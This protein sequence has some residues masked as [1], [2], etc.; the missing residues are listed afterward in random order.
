MPSRLWQGLVCVSALTL[1][2]TPAN[3]TVRLVRAFMTK[4][5]P[6]SNAC[7]PTPTATSTFL[8]TDTAAYL[9]FEIENGA[10]GDIASSE[11]WTPS[12]RLLTT[13]GGAWEPLED[14]GNYCFGEKL[15]IA[16]NSQAVEGTWTVK[17]FWNGSLLAT[18]NFTIS[19]PS[20]GGGSGGG[21]GGSGGGAV[22]PAYGVNLIRNG[23]AEEGNPAGCIVQASVP[24]WTRSQGEFTTCRYG[25]PD[26]PSASSPGPPNRGNNFFWGGN[27]SKSVATQSIDVGFAAADIDRGAVSYN[28]SGYLGGYSSQDD[29]VTV[30]AIFRSSPFAIAGQVS[31]GPVLPAERQNT[32]GM[33]L[34]SATGTVPAGTRAIEIQ[35]EMNR[36]QGSANDGYA[37]NLSLVLTLGAA[38][39]GGGGGGAG[40]GGLQININQVIDTNCPNNKVIVSVTDSQGQ[41][42]S[43]L[44]SSNFTLK[45]GGQTRSITVT[46]VGAGGTSGAISLVLLIDTSS[47]LSNTDLANEKAAAKQLVSQLGASDSVAVYSF[48]S[49]VYLKQNFTTDRNAINTAIDSLSISGSTAL[50]KAV[51][52]GA[53]ALAGRTGRKA[54]VLMTDGEDTVG[55]VTIDQAIAAAKQA[56]VPVFTVGF[57][58]GIN[59]TVLQRIAQE[60]GGLFSTGASSAD[61]QRILQ[62]IGQAI[63]SQYEI[64]YTSGNPTSSNVIEITVSY[65]GQTAT[66]TRTVNAC[67]AGGGGGGGGGGGTTPGCDYFVQPL[68]QTIGGS[69]GTGLVQ[70]FTRTGCAWTAVSNTSWITIIAGASGNGQGAVSYRVDANPTASTRTGTLSIA[71]QTHTVTQQPGGAACVSQVSPAQIS[72]SGA[73]GTI[74]VMVRSSAGCTWTATSNVSWIKLASATGTASGTATFTVDPNPDTNP[75][76][77]TVTVGGQSVAVAQAAGGGADVPVIHNGGLVNAA[78][79]IGGE[80]ARGSFFTIYGA[81]LKPAPPMQTTSYPIP[82]E[83]GGVKVRIAQGSTVKWAYLH[84]VSPTQINAI[85]PSDA[86]LG[87]VEVSVITN[88][89]AGA[90]M[91]TKV[92]DVSFGIF[93]AA[94][95]LGPGIIQNWVSPSESPLNLRS[96]PASPNQIA[97]IWGTGLGP[98]PTPDNQPPAGG[99]LPTAVEVLVG[100]KSAQVLYKGR[101]PG[102]A[103]VDNIYIRVPADTPEGCSVPVQVRAAG[104]LSNTVYMAVSKSGQACQDAHNPFAS[105]AISGGKSGTIVLMRAGMSLQVEAGKPPLNLPLL[106]V[107]LAA[108]V[109]RRAGGELAYSPFANLPP[110]GSCTTQNVGL[111]L[112]SLLGAGS[113]TALDS[114]VAAELDAGAQLT[115][116]G[117]KGSGQLVRL[118]QKN[119]KGPYVG[120]LGG[121]LPSDLGFS[122]GSANMPASFLDAG[123]FTI[124]GAGGKDVGPFTANVN[125]SGGVNW[126]NRDQINDI[127]RS[128]DLTITW[129]GGSSDQVVVILGGTNDETNKRSGAFYCLATAAD[130]RFTVPASV[131]TAIPPTPAAAAGLDA[132]SSLTVGSLSLGNGPTFTAPGLNSGTILFGSLFSKSVNFR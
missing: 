121:N 4:S 115:I 23:D 108:F 67:S 59:R 12:A 116:S 81:N 62:S 102:F 69:G 5:V 3:A 42:I 45:E 122:F 110:V 80:I 123:S 71:G 63:S 92:V 88:G 36:A 70:V 28:L 128:S 65:G 66:T 35:V 126:T 113:L 119:N 39:G 41:P 78:S 112:S 89:K 94:G 55:G 47:S 106:D 10:R 51:K 83:M 95:G 90:P 96:L 18:L 129:S 82:D 50:Y 58:S 33:V 38:G 76:S 34:K 118:D 103:G 14:P 60:T 22:T 56:G 57:G 64:A 25:T 132:S 29:N 6:S 85:L 114:N 73:G 21:S 131:L 79:N 17:V 43:G 127:S 120:L 109:E 8:T 13:P 11:W 44:T 49:D 75:R 46:P 72:V 9:W 53:E 61:L 86:P 105:N 87:D 24:G 111:E 117:P 124:T 26:Y 20:A 68:T 54:I 31:I 19:A 99:D 2:N 130:G 101:A 107:G 97:I 77:G 91:R 52:T 7:T 32:T 37:D 125:L 40:A 16:G 100:G 15:T 74:S 104:K 27:V 98:L 48:S 30:R 84:F 93:S 1:I